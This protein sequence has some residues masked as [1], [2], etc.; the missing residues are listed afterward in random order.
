MVK[1]NGRRSTMLRSATTMKESIS[2]TRRM[3]ME[4]SPGRVAMCT[5]VATRTMRGQA[6]ERCSG[7]TGLSTKENG[8]KVFSTVMG[9]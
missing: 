3:E 6:T 1:V 8:S 9:K 2:L 7:L 5:K 4:Y